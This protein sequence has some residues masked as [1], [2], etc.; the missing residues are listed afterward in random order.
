MSNTYVFHVNGMHCNACTLLIEETF[1]ELPHVSDV[2]ASLAAHQVS[3]TTD[4]EDTPEAIAAQLT[5]LVKSHGYTISVEKQ[6]KNAGWG[7][8]VYAIPI[9]LVLIAGFAML[10]KAG[11]ANLITSSSV[12]Y[13]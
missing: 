10:Q 1:R 11:L 12:S 9:A 6:Q 5:A 2:K 7:D 4:L 3:V 8:F 13:G